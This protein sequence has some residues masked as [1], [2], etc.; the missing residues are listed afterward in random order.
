MKAMRFGAAVLLGLGLANGA[1]AQWMPAGAYVGVSAGHALFRYLKDDSNL[2]AASGACSQD[3]DAFM[4]SAWAGFEFSPRFAVE[5][6]WIGHQTIEGVAYGTLPC[7]PSRPGASVTNPRSEHSVPSIYGVAV[8][9][10][11]LDE[12]AFTPFAK[13]GAYYW[14]ARTKHSCGT[15]DGE[16]IAP[17]VGAGVDVAL[18][19]RWRL[20][21]EWLYFTQGGGRAQAFL[22]GIG[23]K[24]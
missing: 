18:D 6:G 17:L 22:G 24:F 3:D 12:G 1:A 9:R 15:W 13:L 7:S 8:G 14:R 16:E 10:L 19:G 21:G 5:A 11:P 20:R 4:Y 2:C 23:Y